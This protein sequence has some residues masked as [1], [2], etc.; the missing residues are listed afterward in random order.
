M[1]VSSAPLITSDYIV[2]NDCT[3]GLSHLKKN[4]LKSVLAVL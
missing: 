2:T 4:T 1:I 3:T